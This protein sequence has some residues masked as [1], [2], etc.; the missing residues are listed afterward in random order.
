MD[1]DEI[2][3]LNYFMIEMT[4]ERLAHIQ[5]AMQLAKQTNLPGQVMVVPIA[6]GVCFRYV[7]T[8]TP[9]VRKQATSQE[10]AVKALVN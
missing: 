4:P 3:I 8:P 9:P 6:P 2:K 5:N 7:P 1:H 10:T